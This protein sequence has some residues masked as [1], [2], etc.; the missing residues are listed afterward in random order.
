M[1]FE[2][3]GVAIDFSGIG[4]GFATA[5]Y[6]M[7]GGAFLA[8]VAWFAYRLLR[9]N[10]RVY[11]EHWTGS[12]YD[13]AKAWGREVKDKNGKVLKFV[14]PKYPKYSGDKI[15]ES[16]KGRERLS[17]GRSREFV[18]LRYTDDG[19]LVPK[20]PD[21]AEPGWEIMSNPEIQIYT[22]IHD[23][24]NRRFDIRSFWDKYGNFVM[25]AGL[26]MAVVLIVIVFQDNLSNLIDA[27]R[28]ANSMCTEALTTCRQ[29]CE[30]SAGL[31]G[32]GIV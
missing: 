21:P 24:V 2:D 13:L 20:R 14:I 7:L 18:F 4:S 30:G 29:V 3:L 22:D 26:I 15:P 9:N 5:V 12:G 25:Q 32:S 1:V 27:G 8:L 28:S 11:I 23:D 17:L 10:V 16:Y 6:I 19:N 31:A